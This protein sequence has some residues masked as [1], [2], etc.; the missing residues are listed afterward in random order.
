[1]RLSTAPGMCTSTTHLVLWWKTTMQSANRCYFKALELPAWSCWQ[2]ITN[3]P[4]L[5]SAFVS[6]LARANSQQLKGTLEKSSVT[7][8]IL[9]MKILKNC[10]NRA[11]DHPRSSECGKCIH[12]APLQMYRNVL[13]P[14]ITEILPQWM[15]W[16]WTSCQITRGKKKKLLN[17][18]WKKKATFH[19]H[20]ITHVETYVLAIGWQPENWEFPPKSWNWNEPGAEQRMKKWWKFV[21]STLVSHPCGC[22][23]HA[24]IWALFAVSH[25]PET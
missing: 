7:S 15:E 10:F 14:Q 23:P 2:V 6:S 24:K 4:K 11:L 25:H 21:F 20:G 3:D 8:L 16:T 19:H 9:A 13:Y 18:G 22:T 5:N 1:M 12:F 17:G